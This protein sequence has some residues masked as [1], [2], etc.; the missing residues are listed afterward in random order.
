MTAYEYPTTF[1]NQPIS[2]PKVIKPFLEGRTYIMCR[3]HHLTIPHEEG[4]LSSKIKGVYLIYGNYNDILYIGKSVVVRSRLKEHFG[5]KHSKFSKLEV[6]KTS[7]E[8]NIINKYF[9]HQDKGTILKKDSDINLNDL[10]ILVF[11]ISDAI[12]RSSFEL[13]LIK[14]I[15]P[16]HNVHKQ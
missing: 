11:P 10:W 13:E 1:V 9:E 6:S 16:I 15:N 12:D 14:K 3:S 2:V 5:Y 4:G 8:N 7:E